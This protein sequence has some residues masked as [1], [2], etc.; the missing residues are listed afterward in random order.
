LSD[1]GNPNQKRAFGFLFIAIA[2]AIF[3]ATLFGELSF[4][5]GSLNYYS[6]VWIISFAT[7]MGIAVYKLRH[8]LVYIRNRMK[9]SVK[10]PTYAKIIN[11]LCWAGPFLLIPVFHSLYPYLILI[12]I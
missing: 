2:I 12:G 3:G 8:V 11:G 4:Y 9:T 6:I 10:W 7:I 5:S 1:G